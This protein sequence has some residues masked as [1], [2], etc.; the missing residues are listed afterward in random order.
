VGRFFVLNKFEHP[1][2]FGAVVR[3]GRFGIL[4]YMKT[5]LKVL[6][7]VVGLFILS[8]IFI[9]SAKVSSTTKDASET[10]VSAQAYVDTLIPEITTNWDSQKLINSADQELLTIS[11]PENITNS[12]KDI[13]T[14]L[15]DLKN[16]EGSSIESYNFT[17]LDGKKNNSVTLTS[18][19]VLEKASATIDIVVT[20]TN[21]ND[22]KVNQFNIVKK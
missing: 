9:T 2:T 11:S 19:V 12:F 3:L 15:G 20:S 17:T 1:P 18:N 21:G 14:Q 6:G 4:K 7:V 22:W 8:L 13:K 5:I 16:Y 10:K